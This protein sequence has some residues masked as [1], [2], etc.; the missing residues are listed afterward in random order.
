VEKRFVW[1]KRGAGALLPF[2]FQGESSGLE[3]EKKG[4]DLINHLMQR[5][6]RSKEENH[7][8]EEGKRKKEPLIL[9]FQEWNSETRQRLTKNIAGFRKEKTAHSGEEGEGAA[10]LI[11]LEKKF[12]LCWWARKG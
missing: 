8:E 10:S 6:I 3:R 4:V 2:Q 5:W 7:E 11:F 1:K 12:L 9:L